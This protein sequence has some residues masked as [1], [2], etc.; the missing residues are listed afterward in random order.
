SGGGA[1]EVLRVRFGVTATISGLTIA[2]GSAS[3][4]GGGGIAN[5]GNLTVADAILSDN[6]AGY[7][8]GIYN[9]GKLAV[10]GSTFSDNSANGAQSV[11][12]GG[13]I[14]NSNSGSVSIIGSVFTRNSAAVGGGIFVSRGALTITD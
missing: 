12:G 9:Y 13:G 4:D 10:T 11:T 2:G 5:F 7:G 1:I 6:A 14:F 8:G 3:F